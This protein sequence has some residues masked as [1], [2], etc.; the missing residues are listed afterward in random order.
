MAFSIS[1]IQNDILIIAGL[2]FDKIKFLF[3]VKRRLIELLKYKNPP[4]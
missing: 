3:Y 1:F 4:C 2:K